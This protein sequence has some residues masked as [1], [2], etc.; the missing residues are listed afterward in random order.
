M[1]VVTG[2]GRSGTSFIASLY[3]ELGFDTGGGWRA[4][5]NAGLEHP[6]FVKTNKELIQALGTSV[7]M[8]RVAPR[9]RWGSH[10]ARVDRWLER[11][12]PSRPVAERLAR[13]VDFTRYGRLAAD[14]VDWKRFDEV[15]DRFAPDMKALSEQAQV[16]KDPR[17]CWTLPAWLASGAS[18]SAVVLSLRDIDAVVESRRRAF[19]Q[20]FRGHGKTWAKNQLVYGLGLVLSAT[21]EYRVRL[22]TFRFPD[23]LSSPRDV[24]ERLPLPEPRSWDRFERSFETVGDKSLVHDDR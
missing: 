1:I 16:V 3:R 20:S 17:F 11:E 15:V 19:G 14:V 24:Y 2:P 8:G 6:K 13:M 7:P 21:S 23:L 5:E 22:E 12:T 4:E 10:G 9:G 18:V